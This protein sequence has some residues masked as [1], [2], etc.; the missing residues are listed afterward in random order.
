MDSEAQITR[1]SS[2]GQV[3]IPEEIR[4][5]LNLEPG[6]RFVVF[7]RKG[8]NSILLKK[9]DLPESSKAF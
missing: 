8:A 6:S 2:K 1:M 9:L 5:D 4:N 3:V 7:G